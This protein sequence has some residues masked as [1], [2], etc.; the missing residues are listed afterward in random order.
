MNCQDRLE[1][2]HIL[3]EHINVGG[4]LGIDYDHPNRQPIPDFKSY[5]SA[6]ATHLKLRPHQTLHFEFGACGN[7]SM[8]YIDLQSAVREEGSKQ[9]IC[10]SRCRYD[11]SHSSGSLSG[12]S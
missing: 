12:A 1:A 6:Y 2:R 5:F 3:V 4:G 7:G 8:R 10:H 11:R 9:A